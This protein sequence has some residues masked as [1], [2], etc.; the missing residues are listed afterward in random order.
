VKK[1]KFKEILLEIKCFTLTIMSFLFCLTNISSGPHDLE[2]PVFC[3]RSVTKVIVIYAISFFTQ[4]D[5]LSGHLELVYVWV[6]M[7]IPHTLF[8]IFNNQFEPLL[9][10]QIGFSISFPLFYLILS[11]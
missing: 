1:F 2:I 8:G 7:Q 11:V 5:Q 3:Y 4:R 9:I 10:S 6:K